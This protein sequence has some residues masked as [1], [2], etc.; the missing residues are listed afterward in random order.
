MHKNVPTLLHI[1]AKFRQIS[2]PQ[3]NCFNQLNA[4]KLP[5]V[6]P[7]LHMVAFA[8]SYVLVSCKSKS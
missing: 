2:C 1:V 3:A 8:L 5:H 7:R 6:H 4:Q